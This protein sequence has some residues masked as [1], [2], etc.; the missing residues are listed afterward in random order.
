MYVYL[1]LV[2][3][4]CLAVWAQFNGFKVI[5]FTNRSD[6][7]GEKLAALTAQDRV[8]KQQ[9]DAVS[10]RQRAELERFI[11]QAQIPR[12]DIRHVKLQNNNESTREPAPPSPAQPRAPP[13]AAKLG[14]SW[15]KETNPALRNF[16]RWGDR[17]A[18]ASPEEKILIEPEGRNLAQVRREEMARLISMNPAQAIA[19]AVPRNVSVG[20]TRE[21]R[22]LLGNP[23]SGIGDLDVYGVTPG[24]DTRNLYSSF[25]R[26]ASIN[27]KSYQV[28][29]QGPLASVGSQTGVRFEG[30]EIDGQAALTG[31]PGQ[32]HDAASQSEHPL[33]SDSIKRAYHSLGSNKK[34]LVI[35]VD[36]PDLAG[37]EVQRED[38]LNRLKLVN[39]F[40]KKTSHGLFAFET[41]TV[42][43]EVIRLPKTAKHY[44]QDN[45]DELWEDAMAAAKLLGG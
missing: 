43:P 31:T 17:Y 27:G 45:Y 29:L 18:K 36:F 20:L 12:A 33:A 7:T 5:P 21:I 22:A 41:I 19:S 13:Q 3:T 35:Q 30:V 4:V 11:R 16:S 10:A 25:I 15:G 42:P 40:F 14:S 1:S 28:T 24:P 6:K 23:I 32:D 34:L 37:P 8:A 2:G 44:A 9:K 39:G 38:L 26:R